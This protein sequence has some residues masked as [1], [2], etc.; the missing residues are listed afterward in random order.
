MEA[1]EFDQDGYPTPETLQRIRDWKPAK[2]EKRSVLIDHVCDAWY[3]P[4]AIK[5]VVVENH[6]EEIKCRYLATGGWSG[7]EDLMDEMTDNVY[8]MGLFF[9]QER[10]GAWWFE[11]NDVF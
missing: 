9:R 4:D 7:N 3:Y 8:A 2:G 10:G 11:L 6:G 1:A 5:D